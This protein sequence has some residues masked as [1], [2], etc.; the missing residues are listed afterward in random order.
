MKINQVIMKAIQRNNNM[1]ITAHVVE[2][3]FS[4][5]ILSK[6]VKKGLLE[7]NRQGL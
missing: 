4:R 2:L 1:I 5:A 3:G 6:Y 7:R